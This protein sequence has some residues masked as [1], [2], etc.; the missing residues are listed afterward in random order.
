MKIQQQQNEMRRQAKPISC[1]IIRF[2]FGIVVECVWGRFDESVSAVVY[3]NICSKR[4]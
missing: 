3:R 2:S 1:S 4:F